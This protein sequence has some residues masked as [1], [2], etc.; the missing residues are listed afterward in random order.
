MNSRAK[1]TW[2]PEGYNG[3]EIPERSQKET[4]QPHRVG[5]HIPQAHKP[6]RSAKQPS[7]GYRAL[8]STAHETCSL[9]PAL[10]AEEWWHPLKQPHV[11]LPALTCRTK[12]GQT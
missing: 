11:P 5:T 1:A 4:A 10:T 12:A 2:A 9:G 6:E 7:E 8:H 3:R